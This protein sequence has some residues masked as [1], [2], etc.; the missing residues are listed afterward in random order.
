MRF[1]GW[2]RRP[3]LSVSIITRN[4]GSRLAESIAQANR[5]A[6]EV[7]V[8]VDADSQDDTW[9]VATKFADTVYR[10]KHPNQ[11]A[12]VHLLALQY[13]RGEW[14]LRLD[15]DEY[16]EAGFESIVA[17]LMRTE[18]FTHYYL[19]RKWVVSLDPPH[20]I[21]ALPWYPDYQLRLIRNDPS[22]IW[23][24]PRYHSGYL[25]AGPGAYEARS[26]I[27]HYEP[28][29]CTPEM[30]ERKFED[31]R[32]GG[33]AH[34]P[35]IPHDDERADELRLFQ[36]LPALTPVASKQ[37]RIDDEIHHL[38][39]Q[40]LPF[41]QCEFLEI[42]FPR[43]MAASKNVVVV[44]KVTNTGK[45][46]WLPAHGNKWPRITVSFHVKSA[47]GNMIQFDGN[48]IE[49]ST[50]TLPG[51]TVILP[52]FFKAPAEPGEYILTWDMVSEGECWFE[53]CGSETVDIP[54]T[55][56]EEHT[57]VNMT[58]YFF[59]VGCPRS[60]TTLLS[61]LLDRHTRLC[62]PPETAFFDELAPFISHLLD[63]AAFL[64]V[65]GGWGRLSEFNIEPKMV[66]ER[67]KNRKKTPAD[68]L[69]AILDIYA[70]GQG[71]ARC[72]EKTPQ[73]LRHV[74][75]ILQQ[76]P[77]AKIIC[78]LRD[79]RETALSLSSM[80][81]WSPRTLA[82]AA[83]CWKTSVDLLEKFTLQ[84]PTQFKLVRYE[85]LVTDPESVLG[86]IM[87]YLGETF[88][89][90]QLESSSASGIVLSRSLAWK[91]KALEPIDASGLM[92]H[93]NA[94]S[95]EQIAFLD[96]SLGEALSRHGYTLPQS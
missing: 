56:V 75:S 10:F 93:R 65:L 28:L 69:A 44:I 79:G 95:V 63:D 26:A 58:D 70:E 82:D 47:S 60:G 13:C 57:P 92:R 22:I 6:D 14:I 38:V 30:R 62:I 71:K 90:G 18:R 87:G 66:V 19:T 41:W 21:H 7:V 34:V 4:S 68:V 85:D 61:V 45:M 50:P 49:V 9:D 67:L 96:Q 52:G 36:P 5:F 11:L 80:P 40:R 8:G 54:I 33:G 72:G 17:R 89:P 27:L 3:T 83:D 1:E 59:I 78:M 46:T 81:W 74:P 86:S 12:P 37:K 76:F 73:H 15:D 31:Y 42:D 55:V 43:S 51:E 53:E 94:A 32:Q 77:A 16:M 24:P 2:Q 25:V 64:D 35:L 88:E 20:Y 39:V 23:K 48:R 84:Y 29:F 91:G